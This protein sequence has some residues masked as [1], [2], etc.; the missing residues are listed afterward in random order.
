M[1]TGK[2]LITSRQRCPNHSG[3]VA[4]ARGLYR[5]CYDRVLKQ[6][7]PEYAQ[8]QRENH[9][10]WVA[11]HV[12]QNAENKKLWRLKRGKAYS[13]VRCLRRYGLTPADYAALLER[14]GGACGICR[15]APRGG[16]ALNVDHCHR[17]GRVRGLLCFRCNFGLS[18]FFED[19]EVMA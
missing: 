17:T 6:E 9:R 15:A 14:Q 12:A 11:Q 8:R 5:S 13:R 7:N 19:V 1:A 16:K 2:L 10:R 3:R 18:F 4:H